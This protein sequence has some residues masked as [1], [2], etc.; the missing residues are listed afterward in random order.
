MNPDLVLYRFFDADGALLY[1]GQSINPWR[2]LT[3]HS[4]NIVRGGTATVTLERGFADLDELLR[5]EAQAIIREQPRHNT[6]LKGRPQPARPPVGAT[7]RAGR[8]VGLV[9]CRESATCGCCRRDRED[10]AIVERVAAGESAEAVAADLGLRVEVV[11]RTCERVTARLLERL[12][13]GESAVD[14]AREFGVSRATVYNVRARAAEG[15]E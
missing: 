10:A 6:N 14:L 15:G 9:K 1:V 13:G 12:A 11:D 8:C 4:R 2:R 5:A 7:C 3:E